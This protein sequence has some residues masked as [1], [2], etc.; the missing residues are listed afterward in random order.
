MVLMI[1]RINGIGVNPYFTLLRLL[2]NIVRN[3]I[4][5]ITPAIIHPTATGKYPEQYK[6]RAAGWQQS[7]SPQ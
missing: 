2:W 1:S 5:I 7:S 6:K 3:R 4:R